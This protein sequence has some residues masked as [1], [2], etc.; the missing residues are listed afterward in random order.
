MKKVI[1]ASM[2]VAIG[3][4]LCNPDVI[5][6]YPITPQTHIVENLATFIHNG[7]LDTELIDVESEH[8]AISA[9]LGAQAAGVRTFTA[10]ASQGLALMHEVLHVVSGMRLPVVMAV[11]NRA[12]SAPINIWNDHQDSIS[13]RDTGWIQLYVES[14]Q[15]A[16]D[17]V[18]MAYKVAEEKKVLLP[19]MVCLDGF[20]LSHVYE[21]VDIPEKSKVKRFLPDYSPLYK[22]DPK[23]PVT[24]GPIA[25]PNSFMEFKKQEQNG[26]TEALK[27]IPKVNSNF[28]KQFNRKYGNGLIET[29]KIKDAQHAV[30]AMGTICTTA[31]SAVDELRKKG[32][33]AG[34]IK[35]RSYRPFPR[36]EIKN[37]TKKIKTIAVLDRNISLGDTGAVF[38]DLS[39]ALQDSK[40]RIN[41]FIV[42]LGGRDV[43][44]KD[45]KDSIEQTISKKQDTKWINCDE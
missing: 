10:T 39:S 19:V 43:T 30:V 9:C 15:E 16:L 36:E 14:A 44:K 22:L 28:K 40:I 17:T 34:M 42:G 6:A 23:D 26:M 12:L 31:R 27:I 41:D 1:E 25:F 3:A 18:I 45:I 5:G 38:S 37:I 20:T 29:Y 13:A 33:K 7:E 2:A 32:I 35:I 8:S 21:P 11:A 4:K 24:M